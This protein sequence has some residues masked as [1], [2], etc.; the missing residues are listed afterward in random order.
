MNDPVLETVRWIT[1]FILLLVVV[2]V[3]GQ[4][5]TQLSRI[6]EKVDAIYNRIQLNE[7]PRR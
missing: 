7:I 6:E 4:I 2:I 5:L 3:S 1:L